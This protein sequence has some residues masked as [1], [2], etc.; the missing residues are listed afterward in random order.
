MPTPLPSSLA[1]QSK[2]LCLPVVTEMYVTKLEIHFI[3][4]LD[5]K[6]ERID[7]FQIKQC[8][9]K[10]EMQIESFQIKFLS[11]KNKI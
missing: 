10:R 2:T 6:T 4:C 11:S 7:S 1:L 9:N 8:S 3:K 5:L